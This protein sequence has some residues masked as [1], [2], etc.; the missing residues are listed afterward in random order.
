VFSSL[1]D[2]KPPLPA[3][4][5]A[6]GLS[7]LEGNRREDRCGTPGEVG[8]KAT[9]ANR[10]GNP[11]RGLP[12]LRTSGLRPRRD[13]GDGAVHDAAG[14]RIASP[15]VQAGKVQRSRPVARP[16]LPG[17]SAELVR[18]SRSPRQLPRDA[19]CSTHPDRHRPDACRS[20]GGRA[21][22]NEC[23]R[24]RVAPPD[25]QREDAGRSTTRAERS[26]ERI[27]GRRRRD[28]E[29]GSTHQRWR[30]G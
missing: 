23:C 8:A 27:G 15:M 18:I 7:A 26:V 20:V 16:R 2:Q 6:A 4:P 5:L 9:G 13:A 21:R 29:V 25:G 12:R 11:S 19:A 3:F 14:N 28:T 10:P 22:G 17:R 1:E 24:L 30:S